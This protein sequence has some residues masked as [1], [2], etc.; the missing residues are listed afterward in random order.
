MV[1][2]RKETCVCLCSL[3]FSV[4]A[5]FAAFNHKSIIPKGFNAPLSLALT[6]VWYYTPGTT[7]RAGDQG[8]LDPEG[9]LTLTGRLKELINRGGEKISPLEVCVVVVFGVCVWCVMFVC[10]CGGGNM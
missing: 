9:Y 8:F 7:P 4:H 1:A 5:C 2:A 6:R 10:V 3:A